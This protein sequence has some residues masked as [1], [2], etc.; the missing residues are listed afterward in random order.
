VIVIVDYGMGNLGS[1]A[2]MFKKIGAQAR[3]SNDRDTVRSADKL[4]LP[5]IG[6]FDTGM[7]NLENRGLIPILR[8][9]V[10]DQGV[11]LLGVCLGMQL[12]AESSEEGSMPGL[13]WLR[14]RCIRFR[15]DEAD[16]ALKVPHMGW[17]TVAERRQH[18]AFANSEPDQRFYFVHS[19][20]VDCRDGEDVLGETHYGRNFASVVQ[21]NNI[22]GV[23]FHPEKSH[24]FG[25]TLLKR[26]A[27]S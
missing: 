17:N 3:I 7:T 5:G 18:W 9:R 12:L 19:Y 13:G 6:A 26:F 22:L 21:R 24:T 2:N 23:Q 4:V 20:F 16:G 15:S 27:E 11:P 8:E 10:I 1:M 14:A 25:M